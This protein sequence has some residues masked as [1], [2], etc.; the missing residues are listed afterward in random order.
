MLHFI[1]L[2]FGLACVSTF[3]GCASTFSNPQL[4]ELLPESEYQSLI[5]DNTQR[6]QVYDGFYATMDFS[7]TLINSKVARGIVDQNARIYQ[8]APEQYLSEKTKVEADL[9]KRTE[10]FL[11]FFVPE[12]KHDDLHKARTL[13]KIFLDV[14]GRRYEGKAT[15]MK[16]ILAEVQAL[17]PH[18]NRFGT[19]YKISFPVAASVVDANSSKLTLTGP[20]GSASVEFE[21]K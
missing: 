16:T 13:W 17:F 9:V 10:I 14:G 19:P 11:S 8:W 2:F 7:A 5:Q 18:H 20:V 3:I 1:F 12:R 21:V 4:K 6:K 15:K